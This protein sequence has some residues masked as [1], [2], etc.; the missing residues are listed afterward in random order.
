MTAITAPGPERSEP[1][2]VGPLPVDELAVPPALERIRVHVWEI[3]V[4]LTHWVTFASIVVLSITGA[5][6]ADPFLLPLTPGLMRIVRF[7]HIVFAFAFVAS[8]LLR[9]YWLFAGNQFARWRAFVP[10]NRRHL[11]EFVAQTKYYAFLNRDLPGI[12]GHNALAGGT[13]LVVFFLFLVQT[14]TGFGLEAIHGSQPWATLFGWVPGVLFGEQGI[15]LIHH[16]LM[17]VIIAFAIHHVYSA[18]LIDHWEH[19]GLMS[20][21]FSGSKF[22][23]RWRIDEARDGGMAFEQL[24]SRQDIEHSIEEAI[25]AHHPIADPENDPENRP[26]GEPDPAGR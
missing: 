24:V 1:V 17:W 15:R 19:N 20:S 3:P 12:L 16:L 14:V 26:P 13:Y 5:Y 21:I 9:T 8:G 18:L 22:V 2:L 11:T 10:T 25:E 23:Q 6:I 4:R 7:V